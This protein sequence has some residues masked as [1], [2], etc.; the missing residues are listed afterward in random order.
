MKEVGKQLLLTFIFD[1]TE[2]IL[3]KKFVFAYFNHFAVSY[4]L[5]CKLLH[6]QSAIGEHSK[7]FKGFLWH[8]TSFTVV[9]INAPHVEVTQN[10]FIAVRGRRNML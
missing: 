9:T 6:L 2:L 7:K 4:Q 3:R 8:F 5:H 10:I 1:Y